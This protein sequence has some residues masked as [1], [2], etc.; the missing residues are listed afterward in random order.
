MEIAIFNT[1]FN[2]FQYR[3][4]LEIKLW[5]DWL[6]DVSLVEIFVVQ[7]YFRESK[8]SSLIY[9]LHFPLSRMNTEAKTW[10]V[11]IPRSKRLYD[12]TMIRP[13]KCLVCSFFYFFRIKA[14]KGSLQNTMVLIFLKLKMQVLKCF[15][16]PFKAN[17]SQE[18]RVLCHVLRQ[19][20]IVLL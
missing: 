6:K 12:C 13:L 5:C 14:L 3:S 18:K 2:Q 19:F 16:K 9:Q 4:A 17:V 11:W 1:T 10:S 7:R 8:S 15:L 20:S